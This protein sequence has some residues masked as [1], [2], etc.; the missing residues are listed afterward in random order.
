ME[1][2][3]HLI[4]EMKGKMV[5]ATIPKRFGGGKLYGVV[6]SVVRD[7]LGSKIKVILRSGD[8]YIFKEP[9]IIARVD[10]NIVFLYGTNHSQESDDNLF[11]ELRRIGGNF[12]VAI[13][14]ITSN[15][16]CSIK[17]KVRDN[18]DNEKPVSKSKGGK[19]KPSSEKSKLKKKKIK[20]SNK[21]NKNGSKGNI[22]KSR[23]KIRKK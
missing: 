17:F 20:I 22:K 6:E 15:V 3:R 23:K 19:N 14:N 11:D 16:F 21:K 18:N 1:I 5:W 10:N 2:N 12:N 8:K 13:N 9:S 7:V 4:Y